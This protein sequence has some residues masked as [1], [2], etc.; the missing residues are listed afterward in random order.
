MC[1]VEFLRV[2]HSGLDGEIE[3]GGEEIPG[4]GLV[5]VCLTAETRV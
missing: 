2:D 3:V 4:K 5:Q 1:N